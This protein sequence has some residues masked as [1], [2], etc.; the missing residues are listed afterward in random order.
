MINELG[1]KEF[2]SN[3]KVVRL[4]YLKCVIQYMTLLTNFCFHVI[5][6]GYNIKVCTEHTHILRPLQLSRVFES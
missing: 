3:Q 6:M 4:D 2:K 5:L 1:Q